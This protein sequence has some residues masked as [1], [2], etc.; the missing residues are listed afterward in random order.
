MTTWDLEPRRRFCINLDFEYSDCSHK[1]PVVIP[2]ICL[3]WGSCLS[4]VLVFWFCLFCFVLPLS[5]KPACRAGRFLLRQ[6][7]CP[8]KGPKGPVDLSL[9]PVDPSSCVLRCHYWG[10]FYCCLKGPE[11]EDRKILRKPTYKFNLTLILPDR[12]RKW[13]LPVIL[14]FCLYG[15]E[16][17]A[18]DLPLCAEWWVRCI[19]LLSARSCCACRGGHPLDPFCLPARICILDGQRLSNVSHEAG[20]RT[21]TCMLKGEL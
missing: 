16:G 2:E 8:P 11:A 12:A 9:C 18:R 13:T 10:S 21:C 14:G 7:D 20:S 5:F 15:R 1:C 19:I 6:R 17:N 4:F 3:V